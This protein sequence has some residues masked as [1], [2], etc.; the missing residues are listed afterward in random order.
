MPDPDWH[1]LLDDAVPRIAVD[2]SAVSRLEL[3]VRRARVRRRRAAVAAPLTAAA[4]IIA[5]VV[6]AG[7]PTAHHSRTGAAPNPTVATSTT[8]PTTTPTPST[9]PT[10]AALAAACR[11]LPTPAKKLRLPTHF[12]ADAGALCSFDVRRFPGDGTWQVTVVQALSGDLASLTEALKVTPPTQSPSQACT[13]QLDSDP[14]L[15]LFDAANQ[16]LVPLIPRDDCGHV[17]RAVITALTAL[18]AQPVAV[19]KV[20]QVRTEAQDVDDAAA[21]AA[22]CTTTTKEPFNFPLTK[23]RSPGGALNWWPRQVRV[24]VYIDDKIDTHYGNFVAERTLTGTAALAMEQAINRPGNRLGCASHAEKT[25][26]VHGPD[27]SYAVIELGACWRVVRID[28]SARTVGA[29]DKAQVLALLGDTA[30]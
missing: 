22:G 24:C 10:A 16:P 13:L 15:V 21:S 5:V 12:G 2:A 11:D 1:A 26:V 28:G 3:S 6:A 23:Q 29:A 14:P 19:L 27:G 25:A 30:R 20:R 8:V 18:Q 9:G 4:A 17:G 7:L